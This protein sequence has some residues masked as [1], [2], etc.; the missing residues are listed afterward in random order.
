[1][2]QLNLPFAGP[3]PREKRKREGVDF[4]YFN[5]HVSYVTKL[6]TSFLNKKSI[7][8][9]R[10]VISEIARSIVVDIYFEYQ[11]KHIQK[12]ILERSYKRHL[13]RYLQPILKETQLLNLKETQLLN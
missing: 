13:Y 4:S 6:I 3:T 9:N 11:R 10:E 7:K 12:T 8:I 1:M 5:F 2:L